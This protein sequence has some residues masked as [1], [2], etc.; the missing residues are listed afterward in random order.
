[1]RS[2]VMMAHKRRAESELFADALQRFE[3][4]RAKRRRALTPELRQAVAPALLR[5]RQRAR[6]TLGELLG[7]DR[8][9]RSA[10]SC[11]ESAP[12]SDAP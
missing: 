1:M 10:W 2:D 9:L 6:A 7:L 8:V 3:Q 5:V 11:P 4:G 12:R